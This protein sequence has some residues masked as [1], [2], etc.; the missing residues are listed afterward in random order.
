MSATARDFASS[1]ANRR[2]RVPGDDAVELARLFGL[3]DRE[4]RLDAALRADG[5]HP[6]VM[7]LVDERTG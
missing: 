5:L 2:E 1:I 4:E 7:P 3:A 6:D